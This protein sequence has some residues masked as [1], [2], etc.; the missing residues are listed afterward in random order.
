MCACQVKERQEEEQQ[1][2]AAYRVYLDDTSGGVE[3]PERPA[4]QTELLRT[5]RRTW[6]VAPVAG[7][8]RLCPVKDNVDAGAAVPHEDFAS[9]KI[10]SNAAKYCPF[11]WQQM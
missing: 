5:H 10:V 9:L 2:S 3:Y 11:P 4:T 8:D 6:F 7:V 1:W